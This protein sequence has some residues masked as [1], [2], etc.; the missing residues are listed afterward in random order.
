MWTSVYVH[1]LS[2]SH[3][4]A[5]SYCWLLERQNKAVEAIKRVLEAT[6]CFMSGQLLEDKTK[7]AMATTNQ[8]HW[9]ASLL[10]IVAYW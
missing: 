2:P 8:I 5:F 6:H 9:V 10:H 1:I 7:S 3:L 4:N